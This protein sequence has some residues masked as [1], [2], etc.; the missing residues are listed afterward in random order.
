MESDVSMTVDELLLN[1]PSLSVDTPTVELNLD[2]D[3]LIWPF[4]D[5]MTLTE[6]SAD[7][8]VYDVQDV[9]IDE[10]LFTCDFADM[11]QLIADMPGGGF[12]RG[13]GSVQRPATRQFT[14]D[15]LSPNA[16]TATSQGSPRGPRL[17]SP[18]QSAAP[19]RPQVGIR[20]GRQ[21]SI[22]HVQQAA[23]QRPQAA[24]RQ[25]TAPHV[26][27]PSTSAVGDITP[28][29]NDESL[30][31]TSR[32]LAEFAAKASS[33]A[34]PQPV[35]DRTYVI[36]DDELD[37]IWYFCT[38]R[39]RRGGN[40]ITPDSV[41]ALLS[42]GSME[43]QELLLSFFRQQECEQLNDEDPTLTE[44]HT[45]Y[46]YHED[47][48]LS[49]RAL[50]PNP[51]LFPRSYCF[52]CKRQLT[53]NDRHRYCA[54]CV[55]TQGGKLCPLT[56]LC[57]HCLLMQMPDLKGRY[58]AI[59]AACQE[60]ASGT[61]KRCWRLP[62]LVSYQYDCNIAMLKTLRAEG[63]TADKIPPGV[64]RPAI[65]LANWAPVSHTKL[66]LPVI[67]PDNDINTT[68]FASGRHGTRV[69]SQMA[70]DHISEKAKLSLLPDD[71]HAAERLTLTEVRNAHEQHAKP[72]SEFTVGRRKLP[73]CGTVRDYAHAA[74]CRRPYYVKSSKR[75]AADDTVLPTQKRVS[76]SFAVDAPSM[77]F[78]NEH[79]LFV[80]PL[81]ND[82]IKIACRDALGTIH[83]SRPFSVAR[84][85]VVLQSQACE[86][87][88]WVA[89]PVEEWQVVD[90][91]MPPPPRIQYWLADR[92]GIDIHRIGMHVSSDEPDTAPNQPLQIA[93]S[94]EVENDD[95]G[96]ISGAADTDDDVNMA[97]DNVAENDDNVSI[98]ANSVDTSGGDDDPNVSVE[99]SNVEPTPRNLDE[100]TIG[101]L[102]SMII[103][104]S[105]TVE[106][107]GSPHVAS[108]PRSP[109]VYSDISASPPP[110][111][112]IPSVTTSATTVVTAEQSAPTDSSTVYA[113]SAPGSGTD[114]GP[115]GIVKV[116]QQVPVVTAAASTDSAS[117]GQSALA[118][119]LDVS[120][121]SMFSL[122][123]NSSISIQAALETLDR[124]PDVIGESFLPIA[125]SRSVSGER[126]GVVNPHLLSPS[127][128]AVLRRPS[129]VRGHAAARRLAPLPDT[130]Q[131]APEINA[132]W[133]RRSAFIIVSPQLSPTTRRH[134]SA[135][136]F[137]SGITRMHKPAKRFSFVE[138]WQ[139][140]EIRANQFY[141]IDF[142]AGL[143]P[144][145]AL[146]HMPRGEFVQLYLPL[147]AKRQHR[148]HELTPMGSRLLFTVN[149]RL[150]MVPQAGT[151]QILQQ[152][153]QTEAMQSAVQVKAAEE[154]AVV[155][156]DEE[157]SRSVVAT[158]SQHQLHEGLQ[159][160]PDDAS[161][162]LHY[163]DAA[164]T[165]SRPD[166]QPVLTSR[167][168][169]VVPPITTFDVNLA[170]RKAIGRTVIDRM[171]Q[172]T[173]RLPT[174]AE[175]A[176]VT[177]WI[178]TIGDDDLLQ[179]LNALLHDLRPIQ[180]AP[181]APVNP[182]D[183]LQPLMPLDVQRLRSSGT[184]DGSDADSLPGSADR[185]DWSSPPP[186][187]GDTPPRLTAAVGRFM[188]QVEPQGRDSLAPR[189][190]QQSPLAHDSAQS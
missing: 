50:P 119:D 122:A 139:N 145:V 51:E 146:N 34:R 73:K 166:I 76:V 127:V 186:R 114:A 177:G 97:D 65:S 26:Q 130:K 11:E 54:F 101:N 190:A 24:N 47:Y 64:T 106:G 162:E 46:A 167:S 107:E 148:P 176:D 69:L 154:P 6:I 58:D 61:Q 150:G 112:V 15:L 183:N 159:R 41:I 93:T 120:Q 189:R 121:E 181:P 19:Q 12:R 110:S 175:A 104:A 48:A 111:P 40:A 152:N 59:V 136:T 4:D 18:L 147:A 81:P 153:A 96:G 144:G 158:R 67:K 79:E 2:S 33:T 20:G 140:R 137:D 66:P 168:S 174:A 188:Q 82:H 149:E 172:R 22:P 91:C 135:E 143:A 28:P 161:L 16:T 165:A 113:I 109:P 39:T 56:G 108:P 156:P 17:P 38:L 23:N 44:G 7:E 75:R 182:R 123:T 60:H 10:S 45:K 125:P 184:G 134:A 35:P 170:R 32:S 1:T 71:G 72:A 90:T 128:A 141:A 63:K 124:D 62:Q 185:L 92:F 53:R 126:R 171:M 163:V 27:Q 116:T 9:H 133:Q 36:T 13:R 132:I 103:P 52:A 151:A 29:D 84:Q 30:A 115:S 83:R 178:A 88:Q 77:S 70:R 78:G 169:I 55:V 3:S 74:M 160:L 117:T 25:Q 86:Q 138:R 105:A 129:V 8:G 98:V 21:P 57:R 142:M 14:D 102:S 87:G 5:L 94:S 187:H 118:I 164:A 99:L 179:A 173:G 43:D 180:P 49:Q 131:A 80:M 95:D 157:T 100:N 89:Q 68:P 37:A 85:W 42:I 31:V 155:W